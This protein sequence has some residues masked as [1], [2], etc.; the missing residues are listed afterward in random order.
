MQDAARDEPGAGPLDD[1]DCEDAEKIPVT[2]TTTRNALITTQLGPCESYPH[3]V[4]V[5]VVGVSNVGMACAIAIL[6]RRTASEVCLVDKDKERARAEAEDIQHAGVFLGCPLV[7]GGSDISS[8]KDST[9]VVV[10]V[11]EPR[12]GEK[13]DVAK[14]LEIFR[15]IVPGIVK[16]ACRAVLVIATPPVEV[17][18]YIAWKFSKLCRNRVLGVGTLVDSVR[19][20]SLVGRRLGLAPSAVHC[21][22]IGAQ[23][24]NSVPVWSGLHVAGTR[25]R[26]VNPKMGEDDD[27]EGWQ[28]V[29]KEVAETQARLDERMGD[30]GPSCWA[31]GFCAAEI[32]DA[33]VRNTKVVLPVA[34]YVHSCSHGT[35][36]DVF[37]SV[38]CVVCREGVH[39]T[40][41]QKLTD[42]EKSAVQTCADNIRG[43][44]RESGIFQ[45]VQEEAEF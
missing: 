33:V 45:D 40:L 7:V 25:L 6:M 44:L 5:S 11:N 15:T 29:A 20:Q 23:G 19:F 39:C 26:D 35:D 18:S 9:V 10:S 28:D 8:V 27:P 37:M 38:P 34:T 17:M 31:L 21:T 42:S 14:N 16:F 43:V 12:P 24:V 2:T 30:R 1:D 32:V 41:R 13:P 22:S 36:K 4:K 3:R